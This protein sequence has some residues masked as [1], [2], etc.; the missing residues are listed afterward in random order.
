MNAVVMEKHDKSYAVLCDDGVF[1]SIQG[2]FEIGQS[3]D[4]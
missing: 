3:I 2:K 1:R 4:V